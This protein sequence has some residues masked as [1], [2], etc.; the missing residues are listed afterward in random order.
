MG[1]IMDP[2][3]EVE[4]E[5]AAEEGLSQDLEHISRYPSEVIVK[6]A[7]ISLPKTT[8]VYHKI[9]LPKDESELGKIRHACRSMD[10]DQRF[11]LDMW[12]K[13][14]KQDRSAPLGH[15]PKPPLIKVHGGGGRTN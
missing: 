1:D 10:M 4:N 9:P 6:A 13:C 5:E 15:K 12:V 14:A 8:S 7:E 2:Q 3:N 11:V